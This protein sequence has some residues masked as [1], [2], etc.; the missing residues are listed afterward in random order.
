MV[1]AQKAEF[2]RVAAAALAATTLLAGVSLPWIVF[3]GASSASK[4]AEQ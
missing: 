3:G 4:L 2:G 1:K